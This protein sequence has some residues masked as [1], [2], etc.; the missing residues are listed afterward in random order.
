MPPGS[1]WVP[2]QRKGQ[3]FYGELIRYLPASPIPGRDGVCRRHE[4]CH[5][6]HR[7]GDFRDPRRCFD[8]PLTT[9]GPC[10]ILPANHPALTP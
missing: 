3:I 6:K 7:H 4:V 5:L 9:Q 10:S 1:I 2:Y 8:V